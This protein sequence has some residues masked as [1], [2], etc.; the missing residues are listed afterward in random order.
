MTCA[1]IRVTGLHFDGGYA[2]YMVAPIDSIA[3]IPDDLSAVDAGPLMCAGITTYNSLR[4]SG[5]RGGD[6]VAVQAIG[7][8]GH[9]GVQFASKL[10]FHTVAISRGGDKAELAR[11]LGAALY[12]DTDTQDAAKE[13]RRLG[14]AQVILATAPNSKSMGALIGGLTPNGKLIVVGAGVDAIEVSPLKIIG[15]R[16]SVQGWASGIPTDSEDAM[17]FSVLTGVRPMIETFPLEQAAAAYERMMSNK[18]RFRVVL[19]VS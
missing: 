1:N 7:G 15:G 14:G 10:G 13:L 12:I 3:L 18:A 9:L 4:N 8:L 19:T 11:K 16:L 17:R 2:E 6:V 5:A